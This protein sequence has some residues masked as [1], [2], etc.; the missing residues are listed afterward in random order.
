MTTPQTHSAAP[1][2]VIP[3]SEGELTILDSEDEGH[4]IATIDSGRN[5][6]AFLMAAAP[7]LLAACQRLVQLVQSSGTV[8]EINTTLV[9]AHRAVARA[10][11]ADQLPQ[12]FPPRG[13]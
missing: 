1:W 6:D 13:A 3:L 8:V 2:Y 12:G 11:G 4:I 5:A 10:I 9:A 7:E